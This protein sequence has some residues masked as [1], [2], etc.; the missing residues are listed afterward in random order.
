VLF[1]VGDSAALAEKLG[2]LWPECGA[3]VDPGAE[4]RA[5]ERMVENGQRYA[6]TFL[7]IMADALR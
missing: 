5:R 3:G 4:R 1:R 7:D 6:R 2:A